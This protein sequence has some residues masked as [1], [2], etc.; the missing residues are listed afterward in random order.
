MTGGLGFWRFSAATQTHTFRA[1]ARVLCLLA[2][3]VGMGA[4]APQVGVQGMVYNIEGEPLPGVSVRVEQLGAFSVS[5]GNGLF[6]KRPNTL[7][8]APGTWELAYFKTGF[9]TVRQRIT[10]DNLRT[11]EA[12]AVELWPLPSAKGVYALEGLTYRPFTRLTPERYLRENNTPVSGVKLLPELK[13]ATAPAM[14]I[15]HRMANYDWQLSRMEQVAVLREGF[16]A[17]A[18]GEAPKEGAEGRTETIW[19]ASVRLPI[20][21]SAIDEPEQQLWRI[22]PSVELG[23]GIYAVHWGALDGDPGTEPSAYLLQVIDPNAPPEPVAAEAAES[24]SAG[25]AVPDQALEVPDEALEVTE[26]APESEVPA[27]DKPRTQ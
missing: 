11:L 14:I 22:S 24:G 19:A 7:S 3:A 16:E 2:G 15:S 4:C 25:E 27:A 26:E 21:A 8:L 12:P 6:G 23:P 10:T 17:P 20:Q 5:N 13:L 9:T 18:P 1:G